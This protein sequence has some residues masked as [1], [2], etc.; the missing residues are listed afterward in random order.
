MA[1]AYHAY[2]GMW[3]TDDTGRIVYGSIQPEMKDALQVLQNMCN[4][5]LLDKEFAVKDIA[6]AADLTSA[7]KCGLAFGAMRAPFYPLGYTE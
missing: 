1:N 4:D 7:G 3:T 2:P 6:K 5:G